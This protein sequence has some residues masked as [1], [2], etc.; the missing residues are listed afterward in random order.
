MVRV[1][2][3]VDE[4]VTEPATVLLPHV[5]EG[6][7]EV[8]GRHDEVV[9]VE[10]VRSAET[11]LIISVGLRVDLLIRSD[12]LRRGLVEVDEL[13]L[14]VADGIH[15]CPDRE[16]FR[17]GI[18]VPQDERHQPLGVG[19]VVDREALGDAEAIDVGAKDAYA[20]R[21]ERRDPHEL[22]P[23]ADEFDDTFTH[24]GCGLVGERD[25][26][27]LLR[28]HPPVTDQM[29]DPVGENPGLSRSGT[30]HH[31]DRALGGGHRLPL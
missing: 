19:V 16:P 2:V 11:L 24:L 18:H 30:R 3:L 17:V 20:G 13:V 21:V 8:D 31:Q 22:R 1:L 6:A 15:H 28:G 29:G 9:E 14:P 7:E 5:G 4:H 27:D 23:V 12:G 25:G 10:R 26:E